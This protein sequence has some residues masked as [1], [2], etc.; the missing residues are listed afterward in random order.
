MNFNP[1]SRHV[2]FFLLIFDPEESTKS[3]FVW[4]EGVEQDGTAL[5]STVK[6]RKQ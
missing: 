3:N 5:K 6:V 4:G 1:L 2:K